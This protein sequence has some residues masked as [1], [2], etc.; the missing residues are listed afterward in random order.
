MN[1][2]GKEK[3]I[4]DPD[5]KVVG[6]RRQEEKRTSRLCPSVPVSVT[7]FSSGGIR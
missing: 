1:G 5:T 6:E 7:A 3:E 2:G 4:E